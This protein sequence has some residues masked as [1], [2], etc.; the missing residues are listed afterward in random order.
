MNPEGVAGIIIAAVSVIGSLLGMG[1]I[2]YR[3]GQ[4][5]GRM[6]SMMTQN[7]ADHVRLE[8]N[9]ATTASALAEHE[10]WHRGTYRTSV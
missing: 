7:N 1:G 6:E 3:M 2:A 4:I 8:H 9:A 10:R 5:A